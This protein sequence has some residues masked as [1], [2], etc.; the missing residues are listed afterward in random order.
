MADNPQDKIAKIVAGLMAQ[1]SSGSRGWF[2][3]DY[4]DRF[5]SKFENGVTAEVESDRVRLRDEGGNTLEEITIDFAPFT[6]SPAQV[7]LGKSVAQLHEL[8]R[9]TVLDVDAKLDGVLD[10]LF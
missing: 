1:T 2:E 9:R 7:A 10:E 8:V 3:T 4:P 5:A 6:A